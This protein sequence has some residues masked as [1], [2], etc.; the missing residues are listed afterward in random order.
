MVGACVEQTQRSTPKDWFDATRECNAANRRLP[1]VAALM[2][3]REV[4]LVPWSVDEI[5]MQVYRDDANTASSY[6]LLDGGGGIGGASA[7]TMNRFR[8]VAHP[9][10]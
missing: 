7:I 3:L 8:C 4:L 6:M 5:T 1:T 10:N 2:Y 9:T